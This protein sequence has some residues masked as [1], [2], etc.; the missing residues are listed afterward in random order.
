[1][2]E[3]VAPEPSHSATTVAPLEENARPTRA[4]SSFLKRHIVPSD[5]HG[6][7]G[8]VYNLSIVAYHFDSYEDLEKHADCKYAFEINYYVSSLARRVESLNLAGGMLWPDPMPKVKDFPISRYEWLTVSV[9]V[10]LMRYI[11]VVD[12]ALL[13]ANAIYEVGLE[14]KNCSL[15]NLKKKGVSTEVVGL[16]K[17]MLDDQGHLR[18]ERNARMHHGEER[19]FTDDD[20]TFKI[21]AIFERMHG[22]QGKDRFGRRINVDRSFKEG[23]VGLQREFNKSTRV[24]VRQLDRLY[25]LLWDEFEDRFGPRIRASTHGLRASRI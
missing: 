24:L 14:P 12:C 13:L 1:M 10:F 16:L 4:R 18:P 15:K 22:I 25:N 23:L 21:G 11:S 20:Q 3:R 2:S 7:I 9:D 19:E 8:R 5:N 6:F 17:K